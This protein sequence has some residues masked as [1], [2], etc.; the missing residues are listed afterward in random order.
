MSAASLISSVHGPIQRVLF[1]IPYWVLRYGHQVEIAPQ[2][3][4]YEALL[5][6]LP[7]RAERIVVTHSEA[8]S[9]A[10]DW[11]EGLGVARRTRLVTVPDDSKFTVW[12]QDACVVRTD[13]QGEPRLVAPSQFARHDDA[14]L[15]KWVSRHLGLERQRSGLMFQGGNILVGDNFWLLGEDAVRYTVDRELANDR[16]GAERR[17]ATELEARRHLLVVGSRLTIPGASS[18]SLGE[19]GAGHQ[20]EEHVHTGNHEG[21]TQPLFDLDTFVSLA[22]RGADGVYRVLVGDPRMAAAMTHAELPDHALADVFD[23]IAD[24]LTAVG[25]R[26]IRNPLPLVHHDDPVLRKR[27]WYFASSNNVVAEIHEE[28]RTVW[29]PTYGEEDF[30]ELTRTDAINERIWRELDFDVQLLPSFHA[31]A[32]GLGAAHCICKC[33][34]RGR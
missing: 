14:P 32:R 19:A 33:L 4:A 3:L 22:G 18:R 31:F 20:W 30:P 15:L 5:T 13:G 6:L 10:A 16:I 11:L 1:T 8:G 2:R 12:A 7:E 29:L 34:S 24:Q 26:V 25:F 23:D 17:F 9:E 27:W 28:A 21:S